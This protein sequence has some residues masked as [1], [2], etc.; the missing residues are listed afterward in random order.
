MW[1]P[2]NSATNCIAASG[3]KTDRQLPDQAIGQIPRPQPSLS[4]LHHLARR[5]PEAARNE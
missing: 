5:Q 2:M 4:V 3:R 1:P